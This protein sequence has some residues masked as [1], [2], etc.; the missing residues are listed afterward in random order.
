MAENRLTLQRFLTSLDQRLADLTVEEI[1]ADLLAHAR[2]L[3]S[4]QR[5]A[6][7]RVF[8]ATRPAGREQPEAH[9]VNA[10]KDTL[11][12]D[13]DAFVHAVSSGRYFD[14]FGWDHEIRAERSFGDETWV[15]EMD[16]LFAEAHDA[17]CA[18]ELR[19]ARQAYHLLVEAF[20]LD[21]EVGTFC[22]P[23]PAAQMVETDLPETEARYLR[24][25]YETAPA[26]ERAAELA[27]AWLELP[28]RP[29]PTFQ[30]VR[31]ALPSDVPDVASFLRDWIASLRSMPEQT[32]EVRRLLAEAVQMRDGVDGLAALARDPGSGQAERYL[33]WV[34]ALRRAH[35]VSEAIAAAREALTALSPSGEPRAR[36]ADHLA[37]MVPD[38]LAAA[39]AARRAAW[40]AAPTDARLLAVHD[41][42]ATFGQAQD[43]CA[44]EAAALE[45]ADGRDR[46]DRRLAAAVMLLAGRIEDAVTL[47]DEP[48]TWN[49]RESASRVLLPYLLAA[50]CAGPAHPQWT[51][52]RM[53]GLLRSVDQPDVWDWTAVG[54]QR[55]SDSGASTLLSTLLSKQ[56]TAATGDEPL[57]REYLETALGEVTRLLDTVLGGQQRGRYAEVARLVACCAEAVA[58]AEDAQA[59]TSF[60]VQIRDRHPRHSAFRRELDAA[61]GQTALVVAPPA[62]CR[63]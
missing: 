38:D 34:T 57:R 39:L 7:L 15:A 18:G 60:V 44:E 51:S 3:P 45:S 48:T 1:R 23:E 31:E 4:D 54:N 53:S 13:I 43:V 42:A 28:S 5:A 14:G 32:R 11:L 37:D 12:D 50:A 49:P 40:R 29:T 33:D 2:G 6:F 46:A 61:I 27:A 17:F 36:V 63:R 9:D 10:G 59:G 19:L 58:V 55:A 52:T 56:I 8:T 47:L 24:T 35:R 62:R 20:G 41:A 26:Q 30:L 22:G 21:Q 16:G 25:V